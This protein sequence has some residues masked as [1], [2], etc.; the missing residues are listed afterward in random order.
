MSI[1]NTK[2]AK[3]RAVSQVIGSLAMMAIVSAVGSVIVF[4]GLSG[5]QGFNNILTGFVATKKDSAGENMMIEHVKFNNTG[6]NGNV[7]VARGCV[8]I[9]FTNI[10]TDDAKIMTIKI[11]DKNG[12]NIILNEKDVNLTVYA[13]HFNYIGY[14]S[15]KLLSSVNFNKTY[16]IAI[17]TERNNSYGSLATGYNT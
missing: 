13:K 5:I 11:L 2:G 15:P 1:S 6:G 8:T 14:Y 17:T 4:Q 16:K 7:C 10:G 3:R 9:W 12:Q